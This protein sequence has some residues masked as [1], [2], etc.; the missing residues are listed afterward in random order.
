[1]KAYKVE[2]LIIDFDELGLD[3]IKSVITNARYPNH[4]MSPD[5]K[6]I[7]EYDI[8]E[9]SDEHPLNLHATAD[10]YYNNLVAIDHE[11]EQRDNLERHNETVRANSND[12]DYLQTR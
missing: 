3:E 7:Q 10:Q 4:C 2:I 1:M 6:D 9:W 5:V 12:A 11:Q 8:G